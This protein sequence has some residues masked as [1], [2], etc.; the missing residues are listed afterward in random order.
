M[1]DTP[2]GDVTTE[3]PAEV[4]A[5]EAEAPKPADIDWKTKAREWER[6]AKDNK[7]A[8]DRL[9][10]IEEASKTEAQKLAERAEKAEREL[11]A[12]QSA[13]LRSEIALTKGLTPSQAKR[14]IGD[15][16]EELEADADQ[17]L[18][19][20]GAASAPRSPRPDP[21]QGRSPGS[22]PK[23]T[24]DSFADFFRTKT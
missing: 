2:E 11:A 9:A 21:N 23:S 3:Q 6:R 8:A 12:A 18:A 15:T 24:A 17:L 5:Q 4:P 7:A 10:A 16:R 1:S 22:G 20:L 19:D 13:S 14:L